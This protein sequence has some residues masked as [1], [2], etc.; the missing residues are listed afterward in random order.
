MKKKIVCLN[1]KSGLQGPD[2][3]ESQKCLMGKEKMSPV[4]MIYCFLT[5][6]DDL[7]SFSVF[8]ESL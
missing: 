1:W 8:P 5:C 2:L 6:L 7:E 3:P 4:Y